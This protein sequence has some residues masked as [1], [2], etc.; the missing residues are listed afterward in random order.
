MSSASG[1]CFGTVF[2]SRSMATDTEVARP[3]LGVSGEVKETALSDSTAC[4]VHASILIG[5]VGP[6]L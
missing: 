1:F 6:V 4:S 3:A 2:S 5:C